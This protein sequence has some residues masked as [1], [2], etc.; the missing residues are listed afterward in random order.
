MQARKSH[1]IYPSTDQR[2]QLAEYIVTQLSPPLNGKERTVSMSPSTTLTD[3]TTGKRRS[4]SPNGYIQYLFL[5]F[6][7]SLRE[8]KGQQQNSVCDTILQ[9]DFQNNEEYP[10]AE[11][12]DEIRRWLCNHIS[13]PQK[14]WPKPFLFAERIF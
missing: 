1:S 8:N 12:S 4:L 9:D 14:V 6:W 13:P 2:E 11:E 5:N 7:Y 10:D 3:S